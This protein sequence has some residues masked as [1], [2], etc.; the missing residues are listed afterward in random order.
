MSDLLERLD[1]ILDDVVV[2][3]DGERDTIVEAK[4]EIEQLRDQLRLANIDSA[5]AEATLDAVRAMLEKW[6]RQAD[7][8]QKAGFTGTRA[9]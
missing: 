5:N 2:L 8:A 6:R 3:A 9:R 7:I 4:D 1:F